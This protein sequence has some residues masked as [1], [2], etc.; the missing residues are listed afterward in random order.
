MDNP[1]R[2]RISA[3]VMPLSLARLARDSSMISMNRGFVLREMVYPD[4][5]DA[6]LPGSWRVCPTLRGHGI[7]RAF[8]FGSVARGDVRR[9]SD[10][11]IAVELPRDSTMDLIDFVGLA[12]ELEA[13]L[14][15]KVDLVNSATMKPRI[16]ERI[17]T[18]VGMR[19]ILTHAYHDE[20]PA[21]LWRTVQNRLSSL[22]EA[23]LDLLDKVASS[24]G[25]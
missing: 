10:I 4:L 1:S 8:L 3:L 14:G 13:A 25:S 7:S 21:L 15:R 20:D 6:Q 11:D 22:R 23:V 16:R 18:A 12:L 2:R 9:R 19:N 24:P 5:A 17:V